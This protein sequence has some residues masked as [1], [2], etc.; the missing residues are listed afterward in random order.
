[1]F[2]LTSLLNKI[3]QRFTYRQRFLFFAAIFFIVTPP[4]AYWVIWTQKAMISQ[5][6]YEIKSIKQFELISHILYLNVLYTLERRENE[7]VSQEKNAQEIV[8]NLALLH[9]SNDLKEDS[10]PFAF[11]KGFYFQM[12]VKPLIDNILLLLQEYFSLIFSVKKMGKEDKTFKSKLIE[13]MHLFALATGILSD[14]TLPYQQMINFTLLQIPDAFIQ[15]KSISSLTENNGS[16]YY[17]KIGENYKSL[18]PLIQEA[19]TAEAKLIAMPEKSKYYFESLEQWQTINIRILQEILN[20]RLNRLFW[21]YYAFIAFLIIVTAS[22]IL[23]ISIRILTKHLV[24]LLSH[25]NALAQGDFSTRYYPPSDDEFSQVGLTL[26]DMANV[27]S[28]LSERIHSLGQVLTASSEHL[29]YEVKTHETNVLDQE[30]AIESTGEVSNKIAA[31]CQDYVEIMNNLSNTATQL[32]LTQNTQKTLS[33]LR[34]TLDE[35]NQESKETL[36]ALQDVL[37]V[38]TQASVENEHMNK[39]SEEAHLLSVNAS[40]EA[41]SSSSIH[42]QFHKITQAI[43]QFAERTAQA[44]LNINSILKET[45]SHI[46]TASLTIDESLNELEAGGL[47]IK[48][49]YHQLQEIDKQTFLQIEKFEQL[50]NAMKKQAFEAQNIID[51]VSHVSKNA[52]IISHVFQQ[53]HFKVERLGIDAKK[54]KQLLEAFFSKRG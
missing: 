24:S 17:K 27:L 4:P 49:M 12:P 34:K 30:K 43:E 44:T 32:P 6:E 23:F 15:E 45:S 50:N 46:E 13:Q 48:E 29:T 25:I 3:Q 10:L 22:V 52:Q 1:M 26:N 38:L 41:N 40:I 21:N 14:T 9:K 31:D 16:E 2:S 19:L 8:E 11:G 28:D 42:M 33:R 36:S 5:K 20:K 35:I 54:L 47:G 18:L 51:S 7:G 37:R 53:L 39:I